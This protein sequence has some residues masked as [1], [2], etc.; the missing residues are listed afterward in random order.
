[1]GEL[2]KRGSIW[3]LRYYRNGLRYEESSKSTSWEEARNILRDREG[4]IAKGLPITPA[5]GKFTFDDAAKDLVT[6][7]EINGR[8]SL[9]YL[10]GR[11]DTGL[12]PYFK[13]RRLAN[14][15]TADVRAY[16]GEA[17]GGRR[18]EGDDQS[19][20]RRAETHVHP[21]DGERQAASEAEDSDA[22]RGQHPDRVF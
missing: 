10:R 16:T 2:R 5:I 13:G 17:P 1:V 8:K 21:R 19:R 22:A 6:D 9:V 12:R 20:T 18:R 15:S 11:I 3:W 4:A 14:I 7:Y